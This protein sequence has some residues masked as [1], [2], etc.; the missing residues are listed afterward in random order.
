MKSSKQLGVLFVTFCVCMI[1]YVEPG[2]A[3]RVQ[4]RIS[5]EAKQCIAC[6]ETQSPSFVQGVAAQQAC[7]ERR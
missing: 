5:A 3:A 4:G 1:V 6:H 2:E 7:G